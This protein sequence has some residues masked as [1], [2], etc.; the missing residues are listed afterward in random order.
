VR[1]VRQVQQKG[2]GEQDARWRE[3]PD[4]GSELEPVDEFTG[5]DRHD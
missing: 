4:F 5:G 3:L 2:G 1:I